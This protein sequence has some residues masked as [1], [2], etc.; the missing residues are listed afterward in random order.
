VKAAND[1][2]IA[3]FASDTPFEQF[4]LYTFTLTSGLVLRYSNCPFDIVNGGNT[5][6]CSRSPGS[7]LFDEAGDSGPRGHWTSGFAVGTWSVNVFPRPADAIGSLPW[8]PAARAGLLDEATVRVDRGYV[9][10]WPTFPTLSLIPIGTVNVFAGRVAELD[11]G[12]SSIT[13]NMNDPRELLATSMPRN[14]FSAACRY[15]LFGPGC[16]LNKATFAVGST[17]TAVS[18]GSLQSGLTAYVDGYFSLGFLR[19]S[20][21]MNSGLQGMIRSS[22]QT[23]GTL[24]LLQPFPFNVGI[25]DAFTVYPGCDKTQATCANK[26]GN[27]AN[28]GGQPY[29][30]VA[31]TAV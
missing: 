2:L 24:N 27:V 13:I 31:E 29:I 28:F 11:F 3:L 20:S 15:A 22:G 17:V 21:G 26:F 18:S 5:W 30:P 23:G 9:V 12:R 4:D 1:A 25:G 19:F 14:L 6:L 16:T 10:A 7:I 8:L